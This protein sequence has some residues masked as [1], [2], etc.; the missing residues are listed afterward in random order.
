[1]ISEIVKEEEKRNV[2]EEDLNNVYP[3][4]QPVVITQSET[5]SM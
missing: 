5:E 4:N 2:K 1:M 3:I